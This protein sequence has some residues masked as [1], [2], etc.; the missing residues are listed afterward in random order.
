MSAF[1]TESTRLLKKPVLFLGGVTTVPAELLPVLLE[2]D[3]VVGLVLVLV[4][5]DV[6]VTG[7]ACA[8]VEVAVVGVIGVGG[9]VTVVPS[10][11]V[12]G[13]DDSIVPAGVGVPS[14][15]LFWARAAASAIN[16]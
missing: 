2:D 9:K 11:E 8:G 7:L 1:F 4:V 14:V 12:L 6:V 15:L 3:P 10:A 13:E 16:C 5:L